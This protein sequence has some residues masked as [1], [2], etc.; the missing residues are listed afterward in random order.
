MAQVEECKQASSFL[1]TQFDDIKAKQVNTDITLAA[2]N[3]KNVNL[4]KEVNDLK[5]QLDIL[6]QY[7]RRNCL[8]I[9]GV[10]EISS[11]YQ[12]TQNAVL[13]VRIKLTIRRYTPKCLQT[14]HL[15]KKAQTKSY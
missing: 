3:Q 12:T 7:S 5:I 15:Q 1:S 11:A 14:Y 6:E 8:V 2:V 4:K 9:N 13:K 10:P